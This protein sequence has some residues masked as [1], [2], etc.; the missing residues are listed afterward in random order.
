MTPLSGNLWALARSLRHWGFTLGVSDLKDAETALLITQDFSLTG[1]HDVVEGLWVRSYNEKRIFDH[2]FAIWALELAGTPFVA[3]PPSWFSQLP[4]K[5]MGPR[6]VVWMSRK[7]AGGMAATANQT[8]W[9]STHTASAEEA[10]SAK[11][12]EENDYPIPDFLPV[13]HHYRKGYRRR[14]ARKGRV[15]NVPKTLRKSLSSGELIKW[16][17]QAER[18]KWRSTVFLWDV[19]QSMAPFIPLFF[20]FF[21]GLSKFGERVDVWGFSTRLTHLNPIW[22][23]RNP[24]LAY[25]ALFRQV[26]DLGGG[27]RLEHTLLTFGSQSKSRL[28]H[29]TDIVLITD[30]YE[31]GECARLDGVL[32]RLKRR[33]RRLNWWNPWYLTPHYEIV[34][35]AGQILRRYCRV[36]KAGTMEDCLY[37][38][39]QLA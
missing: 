33:C 39:S 12:P 36:Q 19:S 17:Y 18:P 7:E 10:N 5:A 15:W 3:G 34:S 37:S 16:Y 35:Q 29:D 28:R 27:T 21:Y 32:S 9:T 13:E 31:S 24:A 25:Q 23:H 11:R 4:K 6:R 26:P 38:W 2:A 8:L 14:P 30:G 20:R 22:E 1:I